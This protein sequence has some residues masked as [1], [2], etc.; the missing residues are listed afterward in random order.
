MSAL[1]T[2]VTYSEQ[3]YGLVPLLALVLLVA[4]TIS[5]ERL[6]FFVRSVRAGANLQYDLQKVNRGNLVDIQKLAKHYAGSIQGNLVKS[7]IQHHGDVESEFE[8]EIENSIML[9]MP[10]LDRN[11]WVLDT[12]VT[13]G[14]LLGLFGT[15]AGMI[16]SFNILGASGTSNPMAVS[17]GIAHAL[18]ATGFGLIIAIFGVVFL[19]YFNKKVRMVVLQMDLIKSLLVSRLAET[20]HVEKR[21]AAVGR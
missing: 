6:I 16:S 19:N 14:P 21:I 20:Q 3:S 7:A 15:I 9:E 17:G 13:L 18:I 5:V 10:K 11:L 8:R 1:N 2:I 12:T 4:L